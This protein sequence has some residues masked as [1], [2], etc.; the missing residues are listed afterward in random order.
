MVHDPANR[1]YAER[2]TAEGKT[3][4]EIRRCLKRYFARHL[5][6][7]LNALH[8]VIMCSCRLQIQMRHSCPRLVR[9]SDPDDF[10]GAIAIGPVSPPSSGAKLLITPPRT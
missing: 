6:R 4:R 10:A 5:Y 7:D 3:S 8:A 2:R 1:A 9:R